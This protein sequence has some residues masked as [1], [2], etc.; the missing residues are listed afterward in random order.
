MMIIDDCDSCNQQNAAQGH[1]VSGIYY[2]ISV[3]SRTHVNVSLALLASM[4]LCFNTQ[5]VSG[6]ILQNCIA[7]ICIAMWNVLVS[8]SLQLSTSTLY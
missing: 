3:P 5:N 8:L 4:C 1:T 7:G 6:A 2:S